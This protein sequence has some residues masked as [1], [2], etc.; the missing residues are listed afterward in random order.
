MPYGTYLDVSDRIRQVRGTLKQAQFADILGIPR[1]NLTKYESGRLPPAD[2]LQ[3]IADYGGV[4]VKWLLTGKEEDRESGQKPPPEQHPSGPPF[5]E[6]V[7]IQEFLLTE[8]L[9]VVEAF[10]GDTPFGVEFRARLIVAVYNHCARWLVRPSEG[11]V[12]HFSMEI[13]SYF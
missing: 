1:P 5:Q 3:K 7:E 10:V 4:T 2:V 13:S 11:L 9:R 6:P 8:V 12:E